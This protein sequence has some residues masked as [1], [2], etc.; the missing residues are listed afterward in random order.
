MPAKILIVDDEPSICRVLS[1]HLKAAGHACATANRADRAFELLQAEPFS[2]LISDINMPGMS[3]MALLEL[4][5]QHF[6]DL[7]VIMATAI[8]DRATAV[9]A[10]QLGAYAYLVK[11]F[12][13]DEVTINV[14]QALERQRLLLESRQY[15]VRLE[16]E[17]R[18]RTADVRRREEELALRLVAA[19]DYRDQDT[20]AHIRRIG[21]YSA[22]LAAVLGW[23]QS[24]VDDLR[25]AAPMHDLGKIGVPDSIL[26]KPGPLTAAEFE[27]MKLH[28]EI[29]AGILSGSDIGLIVMARD[30]ALSHHER[31]DG[32][33]YPH[34]LAGETIPEAARIVT[35]A[36]AYDA[37]VHSRIYKLAVD[38]Q[39]ALGTMVSERGRHFDPRMFDCFLTVVDQFREIRHNWATFDGAAQ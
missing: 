23:E 2:L 16:E 29:G 8:D 22:V 20:G 12:D 24:A 4:A 35:I 7:A 25:I 21:L 17:V 32:S 34:G 28:T 1:L 13:L 14:A 10:M 9:K 6:P 5:R 33:G 26:L 30:I 15:Q 18:D 39:E 11:P 37:M 27:V 3:G 36:D 38:E 19:A 31:W